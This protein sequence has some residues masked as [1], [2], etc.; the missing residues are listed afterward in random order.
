MGGNKGT[1]TKSHATLTLTWTA[2]TNNGLTFTG[3]YVVAT[4]SYSGS[5]GGTSSGAA[6]LEPGGVPSY[7][8]G[9]C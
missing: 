4:G 3:T 6:Q 9:A 1:A 8:G 7:D 5:F 2:G